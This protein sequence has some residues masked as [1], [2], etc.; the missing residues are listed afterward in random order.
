MEVVS[1]VAMVVKALKTKFMD[2]Y[3]IKHSVYDPEL[4]FSRS[5]SL[6]RM[7]KNYNEKDSERKTLPL[8]AYNRS[9]LRNEQLGSRTQ[10]LAY[11]RIGTTDDAKSLRIADCNFDFRFLYV[12]KD[13]AEIE[14]FEI[15]YCSQESLNEN[16]QLDV[17]VGEYGVWPY[18]ITWNYPLEDMVLNMDGTAYKSLTGSCTIRGRFLSFIG[19]TPLINEIRSN[20]YTSES[21]L[22]SND[23]IR[24]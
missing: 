23:I 9:V 8:L 3:G 14:R 18:Y 12:S 19:D 20:I 11:N 21:E 4:T 5:A 10:R 13:M 2:E 1:T 6:S 24:G 16:I 7:D 22:L 15:M 17:D